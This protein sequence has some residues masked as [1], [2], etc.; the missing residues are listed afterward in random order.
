[1]KFRIGDVIRDERDDEVVEIVA[2]RNEITIC[3]VLSTGTRGCWGKRSIG[4]EVNIPFWE[5]RYW[6][7]DEA[8]RVKEIMAKYE[9]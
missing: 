5:I 9:V 7:L 8:Y 2:I 1:M 6:R 4:K 3:K